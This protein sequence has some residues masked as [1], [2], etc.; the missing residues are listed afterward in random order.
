MSH[1]ILGNLEEPNIDI[2][3]DLEHNIQFRRGWQ[4]GKWRGWWGI[5]R[6]Q[7]W[8]NGIPLPTTKSSEDQQTP[9][10]ANQ[11]LLG[12][13]SVQIDPVRLGCGL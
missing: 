10:V 1:Q 12:H 6:T 11:Q 13:S 9:C 4:W 5:W 2:F 8:E 3:G 7:L